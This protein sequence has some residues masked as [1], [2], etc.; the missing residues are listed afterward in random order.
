MDL[1]II[2][3]P[4]PPRGASQRYCVVPLRTNSPKIFDAL[5]AMAS[6]IPG[7]RERLDLLADI[8]C[9]LAHDPDVVEIR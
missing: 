3:Y 7:D 5:C 9:V 1:G 4:T 2:G 8:K 6:V